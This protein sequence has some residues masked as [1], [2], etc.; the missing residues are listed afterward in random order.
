MLFLES[1]LSRLLQKV[2]ASMCKLP[3]KKIAKF[4]NVKKSL[5]AVDISTACTLKLDAHTIHEK[6]ALVHRKHLIFLTR[7]NTFNTL[8]P[9]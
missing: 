2:L 9:A 3:C 6:Q 4:D 1:L 7:V 8:S 5:F